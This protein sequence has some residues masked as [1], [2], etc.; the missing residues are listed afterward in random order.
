[1][2]KWPGLWHGLWQRLSDPRLG[3]SS[4]FQPTSI[5]T[6]TPSNWF[7]LFCNIYYLYVGVG[8]CTHATSQVTCSSWELN[9]GSQGWWQGPLLLDLS[10]SLVWFVFWDS[11]SCSNLVSN[12]P[13]LLQSAIIL[14]LF[15][16]DIFMCMCI[17]STC[18]Y[19]RYVHAW[20]TRIWILWDWS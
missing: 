13:F 12:S 18:M 4:S 3:V 5:F 11:F 8:A 10:F 1:M 2:T 16:N 6:T 19:M 17:L 9:S 20:C 14:L 15:K 7:Y